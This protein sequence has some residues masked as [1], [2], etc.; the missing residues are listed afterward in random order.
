M[1]TGAFNR[2]LHIFPPFRLYKGLIK[3]SYSQVYQLA[4]KVCP[5]DL[6]E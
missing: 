5:A 4:D 3:A 2:S 6:A 1:N